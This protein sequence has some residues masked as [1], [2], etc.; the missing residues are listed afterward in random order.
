[1]KIKLNKILAVFLSVIACLGAISCKSD[2]DVPPPSIEGTGKYIVE[3]STSDYTI[4]MPV[5]RDTNLNVAVQELQYGIE[6]ATGYKMPTTTVYVEG[7]KYLSVG[8]TPL[9]ELNKTAVDG[10]G[11]EPTEVR[12]LTVGDDVI[13][14]G[15][16]NEY[17]CYAVYDFMEESFEFKWYT[18]KDCYY[19]ETDKI[20][21]LSFDLTDKPKM[22]MRCLYQWDYW[23]EDRVL[24]CRRMRVH[25]FDEYH[26]IT[27]GHNMIGTVL[28]KS[29]YATT[30]PEWYT[31]PTGG[32]T[33]GE[34]GQLC[35]CN[36]A[37]YEEFIRRAKIL[38]EQNWG[39]GD[40]KYFMI[41]T[42][43]DWGACECE[44]YCKPRLAI[45]GNHAGNYIEF[46]NKV[47]REL[48][49]W[50]KEKDPNKTIYFPMYAYFFTEEAPVTMVNG[51]Y[52][53][54]NENVVPDPEVIMM[55]APLNN[56]F[57]YSFDDSRN[58]KTYATLQKWHSITKDNFIMYSYAYTGSAMFPMNDLATMGGSISQGL[59]N[60]YFGW[61]EENGTY[62]RFSSMQPLKSYV[63]AQLWWGTDKSV[64]E[65]AFEFIDFYYGPVAKQFKQYYMDLK[66]WQI[67][68]MENLDI[69]IS[70][71]GH[72]YETSSNWPVNIINDLDT[73]LNDM[74]DSLEYL[75]T[76][77]PDL[78]KRYFDHVNVEKLFTSYAYATLYNGYFNDTD[79]NA[80]ID[81]LLKYM[82]E[83]RV[84]CSPTR[85]ESVEAMRR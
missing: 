60:D 78:Y 74:I 32:L 82:Q 7:R 21:L 17:T 85:L 25:D 18:Y 24:R 9:Y 46:G 55:L 73:Q 68:Q 75:N 31:R 26:F 80:M 76:I 49:A 63:R 37:V 8:K 42:E 30:H 4:L 14:I 69:F 79:Y 1:M 77:N 70:V 34:A 58:T 33:Y 52:E 44:E 54:I 38:I 16:D 41:G 47:S 29:M 66:Q 48:N 15:G 40:K 51:K 65:L 5:V 62:F 35:I 27:A 28:P 81:F 3:S 20:E 84:S 45:N 13:M 36:P 59:E 19:K 72:Q 10:D 56:S 71:L 67:Y 64:D 12:V 2:G 83:Y 53:P 39:E 61:I 11:L 50:V 23:I 6:K 57:T 43:D 22:Q